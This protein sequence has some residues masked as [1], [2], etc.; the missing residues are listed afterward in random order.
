MLPDMSSLP[1]RNNEGL[2]RVCEDERYAYMSPLYVLLTNAATCTLQIVPDAYIPSTKAMATVK[3]SPYRLILKQTWVCTARLIWLGRC[4]VDK[5]KICFR[6]DEFRDRRN[7]LKVA[8]L[9]Y[10][11]SAYLTSLSNLK[12][13]NTPLW[14]IGFRFPAGKGFFSLRHL[15]QIGS[16]PHP[17]SYPM[18]TG[19]FYPG[20]KVAKAWS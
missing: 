11:R 16:E 3:N 5:I 17:E 2:R 20:G 6:K 10:Y 1:K 12:Q 15:V 7:L 18:G 8:L 9:F 4:A 19:G 14:T 13:I